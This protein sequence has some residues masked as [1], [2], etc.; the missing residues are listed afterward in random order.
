MVTSDAGGR[1]TRTSFT[2]S[3]NVLALKHGCS[4]WCLGALSAFPHVIRT[5]HP[6][7]ARARLPPR[8]RCRTAETN[9]RA[10][11]SR[12]ARGAAFWRRTARVP[13]SELALTPT[14][15]Q[16]FDF[17]PN[18]CPSVLPRTFGHSDT[19]PGRDEGARARGDR[20]TARDG[21]GTTRGRGRCDRDAD[22]SGRGCGRSCL[23]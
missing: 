12:R 2:E 23:R 1:A 4:A 10:V 13:S 7:R 11:R 22:A 16:K 20:S 21:V 15:V 5:P 17:Y 18:K 3:M 14:N 6:R 19:S 9:F 8:T